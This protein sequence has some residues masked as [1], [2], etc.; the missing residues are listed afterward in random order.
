MIQGF[1]QYHSSLLCVYCVYNYL[2]KYNKLHR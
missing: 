2:N 1:S